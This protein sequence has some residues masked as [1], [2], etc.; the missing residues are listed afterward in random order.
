MRMTSP[1]K[2]TIWSNTP[3]KI[4]SLLLGYTFWY[5]FGS[6]HISS[7]WITVPVC[8]YNIPQQISLNGP[9][10]I[11][12]KIA[13]KRSELRALDL[14]NLAIHINAECLTIGKNSLTLT[15]QS[16]FLPESIKLVH[17]S[18]SNPIVELVPKQKSLDNT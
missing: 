15:E 3:L 6:S 2:K 18:P 1:A 9:E 12:L 13:G 11:A 8:F 7:A 14:D 10:S 4:I 17:Y 5:I 16:L